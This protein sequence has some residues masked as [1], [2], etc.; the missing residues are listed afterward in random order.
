MTAPG[1][2]AI[3]VRQD[4]PMPVTSGEQPVALPISE[5]ARLT[6][7]STATLRAWQRR[8][9]LGASRSS[10]GGH[11]RYSPL[12]VA[13]L[14]AVQQLVGQGLATAEAVRVVLVPAEHDLDLPAE[15]DPVA[16]LL[17]AA[18]LDLDGPSC[19]A[20]LRDHLA[21]HPVDRTWEEVIR[22]AL[23]TV[24]ERWSELPHGVAV[25]HLLS[26]VAAAALGAAA[27]TDHPGP[28][29]VLLACVP[30]EEHDLPLVALAAALGQ[31]GVATTLLGAA[32]PTDTLVRAV[33]HSRPAVVVL[34]ALL[35]ELVDPGML[36]ALPPAGRVVAAGPGWAGAALPADVRR[37]DDLAGA[38]EVVG[39]V[40]GPTRFTARGRRRSVAR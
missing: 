37:V 18:A 40:V 38:L 28:P 21:A 11:R 10:P 9:G 15:A 17:A 20:L 25:E 8:Y 7:L 32:T 33:Q 36:T 27:P 14:R 23:R 30:V 4:E 19:R 6:G 1:P 12:D 31:R 16:H 13:R 29:A 24:G 35:P 5:V 3:T 26:H 2:P 22:P 34:L 39:E